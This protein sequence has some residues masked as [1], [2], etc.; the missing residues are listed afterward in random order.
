MVQKEIKVIYS[1]SN[2]EQTLQDEFGLNIHSPMEEE[3]LMKEVV[4]M[5][6]HKTKLKNL[7]EISLTLKL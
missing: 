2:N 5:V 7:E 4:G 6:L 1:V 3:S